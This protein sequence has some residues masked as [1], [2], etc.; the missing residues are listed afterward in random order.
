MR[1]DRVSLCV[2]SRQ[3]GGDD[4]D[5]PHERLLPAGHGAPPAVR[6]GERALPQQRHVAVAALPRTHQLLQ[7][8]Q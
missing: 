8:L 4:H 7:S 3:A 1:G 6:G 2:G 5:E